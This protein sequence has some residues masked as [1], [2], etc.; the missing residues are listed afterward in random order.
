MRLSDKRY[1]FLVRS[2]LIIVVA[3][4]LAFD[5]V[6]HPYQVVVILVAAF[7][8]LVGFFPI[9]TSR[10]FESSESPNEVA[11]ATSFVVDPRSISLVENAVAEKSNTPQSFIYLDNNFQTAYKYFQHNSAAEGVYGR[12]YQEQPSLRA[13]VMSLAQNTEVRQTRLNEIHGLVERLKGTSQK[14]SIELTSDNAIIVNCESQSVLAEKPN[15]YWNYKTESDPDV[16]P[17]PQY[18]Q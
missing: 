17:K 15:E 7:G 12:F 9:V 14:Y 11:V 4:G 3:A 18:V 8:A 6:P 13:Y 2:G 10:P 16:A 5:R 1:K